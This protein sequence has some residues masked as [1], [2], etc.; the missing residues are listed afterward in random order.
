LATTSTFRTATPERMP[1]SAVIV[2][3]AAFG[4]WT[5]ELF[6]Q[7]VGEP[8]G[9]CGQNKTDDPLRYIPSHSQSLHISIGK[10]PLWMK[11]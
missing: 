4:F 10:L 7:F 5:K 1:G 8:G 11:F 9:N 6:D 3:G 2:L